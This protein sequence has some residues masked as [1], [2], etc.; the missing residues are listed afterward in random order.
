MGG[1]GGWEQG[2]APRLGFLKY[3]IQVYTKIYMCSSMGKKKLT[4][5][6]LDEDLVKKAHDLG[7]NVTKFCEN[8]LKELIKRIESPDSSKVVENSSDGPKNNNWWG[9]P[10]LNRSPESPSLRAWT[11][12]ADGPSLCLSEKTRFY[13][14]VSL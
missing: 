4:T 6:R 9:R 11:M 2:E 3:Q 1:A 14:P 7:L 8:A 5:M 13:N 10:D 12:L